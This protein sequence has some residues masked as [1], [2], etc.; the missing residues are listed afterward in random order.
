MTKKLIIFIISFLVLTGCGVQD[1]ILEDLLLAEV[2]GYD[3]AG[4]NQIRGSTVVAVS[5]SGEKSQM[6]KEVYA[7]TTHTGKNFIQKTEAE[8]S[9]RLVGGR[10]Q[11]VVYGEELAKQGIYDYVDTYRRDPAIGRNLYLAVVDGKAEDIVKIESKMLKTPDVKTKELIEQ[12]SQANLPETN[13]HTF[14]YYYYGDNM[15]PVMP[16]LKQEKDHIRVKGIALFKNDKYIGKHIPYEDGFLFKMLYGNFKNGIYEIRLK[17]NSYM[18]I[19]NI[20]SSVEYNI[21]TNKKP[22][23]NISVHIEGSVVEVQDVDLKKRSVISKLERDAEKVFQ[24]NLKKM[25]RMFQDNDVD[26]LAL[27][28]KARSQIRRFDKKHWYDIYPSIPVTVHVKV[29]LVQEGITE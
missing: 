23:A 11:A 6:G 18:N 8:A 13:L 1:N 5:Q 4:K 28:D 9:K 24:K 10:L 29:K 17:E 16:L 7:A 27:G 25:V 26:P 20:S 12:N 21:N 15:D 19:Q 22:A 2:T 14:L 3:A